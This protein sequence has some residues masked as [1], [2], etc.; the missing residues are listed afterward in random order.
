MGMPM[1]GNLKKNGF[2][3]KAFDISAANLEKAAELGVTP[4]QTVAEVS[5][6]VDFIVTSVPNTRDVQDLLNNP[7]GIFA[8]ADKG[9]FIVDTSTI[10]PLASKEFAAAAKKQEMVFIDSP[11]SGGI[12]GAQ[13]GTLTFMVGCEK[14]HYDKVKE[15]LVGMGKNVFHCGGPGTGEI[16]KICN[17]LILGISMVATSEGLSLGEKLGMDPKVLS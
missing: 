1:S 13:N 11:M 17:N 7:E 3:V 2:E 16:A 15:M 14:E 12:G 6:G 5:K 8:N 10:S 4:V 9:T